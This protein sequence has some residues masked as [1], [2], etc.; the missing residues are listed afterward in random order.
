[1]RYKYHAVLQ[2]QY[3]TSTKKCYRYST[4]H[5]MDPGSNRIHK[6]LQI[7]YDNNTIK[8]YRYSTILMIMW[9]YVVYHHLMKCGANYYV[10]CFPKN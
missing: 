4:I 6:V 10:F 2:I 9:P 3:D 7:Q 5:F 1:M 8:C